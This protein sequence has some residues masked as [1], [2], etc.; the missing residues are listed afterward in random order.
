M[1]SKITESSRPR[2]KNG[3]E[4]VK[5]YVR[6]Q[7]QQ[8]DKLP[9]EAELACKLNMSRY[10]TLRALTELSAEGYLARKRGRGTVVTSNSKAQTARMIAF[11][12]DEFDTFLPAEILRGLE[13][14]FRV[15]DHPVAL[16]NSAY[17]FEKES[18]YLESLCGNGYAG[19][20]VQAGDQISSFQAINAVP[21]DFPLVLVNRC[22]DSVKF[23]W[24]ATDHE[25]AAYEA[26]RYLIE[27]GHR[28]IAH[29]TYE[30]DSALWMGPRDVVSSDIHIKA[31][32]QAKSRSWLGPIRQRL[33]GY[34][35]ALAEAGIEEL[36]E[37]IQGVSLTGLP[38]KPPIQF[39]HVM[40]YEPMH[41]LLA[42]PVRPTAVLTA[43]SWFPAGALRAIENCGLKVPDDISLVGF[44]DGPEAQHLP[45]PLT[46]MAQP[47]RRIGRIA[48]DILWQLINKQEIASKSVKLD[49]GLIVRKSSA[50]PKLY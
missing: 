18:Q 47:L 19:A 5:K 6:Q 9:S 10:A 39:L 15:Y 12:A 34:R 42:L 11:I 26:T 3:F 48:A 46:T 7:Y 16:L 31:A 44:D 17:D 14:Y 4:K 29:L 35:R 38:H 36:P 22:V 24:V 37:Y 2:Q 1:T 27:L 41:R 21:D 28:R 30:E 20:I 33:A 40:A 13:E 25:K 50:P 23:A 8:G 45:V 43:N 49:A 32:Q